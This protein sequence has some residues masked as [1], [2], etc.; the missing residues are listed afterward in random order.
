MIR[1]IDYFETQ[2]LVPSIKCRPKE[3]QFPLGTGPVEVNGYKDDPLPP[4]LVGRAK[5]M[6]DEQM[7]GWFSKVLDSVRL[8]Y[9]KLQRYVRCE[10]IEHLTG[11]RTSLTKP[12][13][14]VQGSDPTV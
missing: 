2:L 1:V 12:N 13:A 4:G 6:S 11:L 5:E 7:V 3:D 14:F 9:R 8:R 10:G